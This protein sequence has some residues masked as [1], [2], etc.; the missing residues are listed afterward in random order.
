MNTSEAR[1]LGSSKTGNPA[2]ED[3]SADN[4]MQFNPAQTE[5][6]TAATDVALGVLAIACVV[7][8]WRFSEYGSWKVG[9]WCWMFGMLAAAAFLGALAHGFVWSTNVWDLLWIPIFLCLGLT[10]ALFVVGAVYDWRGLA[11]ARISL[12]VMVVM[13]LVFYGA[14]RVVSGAFLVFVLYELTAMLFALAVYGYLAVRGTTSGMGL[15]TLGVAGSIIAAVIQATRSVSFTLIWPFDH[16]G[17]FH[18][19]QMVALVALAA[20]IR[21]SIDVAANSS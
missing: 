6:T 21:A 10:V 19:V 2:T 3:R 14:T 13:A 7:Y 9:L 1:D 16:N 15:M 17:A 4:A 20:G 18:L 8:L 12:P 5:L 11:L